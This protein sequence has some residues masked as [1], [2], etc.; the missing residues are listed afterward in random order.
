MKNWT[1]GEN[2]V[3]FYELKEYI[4]GLNKQMCWRADYRMKFARKMLN[5]YTI[6]RRRT[7][8]SI[9]QHLDYL[10]ILSLGEKTTDWENEKGF[11]RCLVHELDEK[12]ID[13]SE[14]TENDE[15]PNLEFFGDTQKTIN[16][17]E[18]QMESLTSFIG[19][20][21]LANAKVVF[22]GNE[23]GRGGK[24]V[25]EN[26]ELICDQYKDEGNWFDPSDWKKGYWKKGNWEPD[27]RETGRIGERVN[28]PFLQ[29]CARMGL[30]LENAKNGVDQWFK[31]GDIGTLGVIS[32]F[33]MAG[34]L[35]SNRPGLKTALIV[36]RPLPRVNERKTLPYQNIDTSQYMNAFKKLE[37]NPYFSWVEKRTSILSSILNEY[38]I[39][40]LLSFGAMEEKKRLFER[41]CPDIVFEKFILSPSNKVIYVGNKKVGKNT[42]VILA[43]FLSYER[44]GYAGA[45][46]LVKFI[47][48]RH[49]M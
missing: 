10:Y 27:N 2:A 19:Y 29:L 33:M 47:T 6:L 12:I 3:C 42:T 38:D 15:E 43:E 39:P 22:F 25:T 28:S 30:A 17:S 31:P 16:L 5:K 13:L 41:I 14:D 49:M 48:Q 24:S 1:L 18:D 21:D 4:E 36:W 45:C 44:F 8:Y 26:L 32:K 34:G 20:G 23:G 40:L 35:Y 37:I 46:D 7:T 9:M 11:Y